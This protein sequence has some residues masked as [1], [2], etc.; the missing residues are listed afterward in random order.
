MG[1]Q[2]VVELEQVA[3]EIVDSAIKIHRIYGPGL[4][5]S[6]YQKCLTLELRKRGL[7]VECE[8]ELPI[9]Y[10][11]ERIDPAYRLDMLVNRKIMIE[12]KTVDQILPIHNAQ[13]LT[14]LRLSRLTLGFILNW[15]TDL[16]KNGIRRLRL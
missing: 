5:E 2:K 13:L 12:N 15:K 3:H 14:Y 9:V 10:E 1:M 4:L 11:G 6:A 8:I 16:M 7:T